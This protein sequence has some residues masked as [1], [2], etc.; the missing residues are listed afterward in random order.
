[1]TTNGKLALLL[2]VTAAVVTSVKKPDLSAILPSTAVAGR[3]ANDAYLVASAQLIRPWRLKS[4]IKGRPADLAIDPTGT[5]AAVLNGNSVVTI[6]LLS[7]RE[8]SRAATKTNSYLGI[9]F[10]PNASEIWASEATRTG[11]D[12]LLR[13]PYSVVA[14]SGNWNGW[15]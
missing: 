6:N 8:I 4:E 2:G 10:R 12:A 9:R 11:P 15:N 3:Q 14:R 1:M 5:F 7:G 13:I